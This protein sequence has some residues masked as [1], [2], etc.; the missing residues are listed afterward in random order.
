MEIT[1]T[2]D[3]KVTLAQ[4]AALTRRSV[5][6]VWSWTST[7]YKDSTGTRVKLSKVRRGR[8]MYVDVV[9][10]AKAD[11]ATDPRGLYRTALPL[12]AAA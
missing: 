3:G 4:A 1:Q 7:G 2:A 11:Y 10:L 8:E 6:T 12:A 9:E 5:K